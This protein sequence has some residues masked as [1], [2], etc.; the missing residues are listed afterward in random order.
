MTCRFRSAGL[1][2]VAVAASLPRVA[3]ADP[4]AARGYELAVPPLEIGDR[5]ARAVGESAA[6][7]PADERA[8]LVTC[9]RLKAKGGAAEADGPLLVDA[10]LFAS[11]VEAA[12][13][14]RAYRDRFDALLAQ[15]RGA[16]KSAKDDRE[17]G[18]VLMKCLH[19]T[20][21][22][23][24]YEAEQSS[25]AGAF[26]TGR[27][28]CVS[29]A[30]V[31]YA[32]GTRLGLKLRGISIPGRPFA[33]GHASLDLVVGDDRVQ[34][35]P[36]TPD[37]F[38]WAA[39]VKRPG[40]VVTGPLPD[41]TAGRE[42][43]ALGIVGMI[44]CNRGVA[45]ASGKGPERAKAARAYAAALALDPADPTAN[46]NAQTLFVNW[47]ADL[48]REKKFDDA[49][50]VLAFGLEVAPGSSS[51]RNNHRVAWVEAIDADLDRGDDNRAIERLGRA[52]RA[53][54]DDKDFRSAGDWYLRLAE[55]RI[56]DRADWE[57]G[58]AVLARAAKTLPA[59]EAKALSGFRGGVYRRWSQALLDKG[60]IDGSRTVLARLYALDPA[61]AG[62]AAGV[63]F[64]VQTALPI[65]EK[66]SAAAMAAHFKGLVEQFP[67][68]KEV[69]DGGAAHATRAVHR[70]AGEKKY[71]EAVT[72]IDGY[73]PLLPTAGERAELGGAVFDR[74]ARH[75][76]DAGEWR[77]A[78]DKYAEGLKAYPGH[79]LL[80][81]N[82]VALVDRWA[83]P[84]IKAKRWD[85]AI[86]VYQ[87]GLGLF[88]GNDHLLHNKKF[89][90][91]MKE[92]SR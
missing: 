80:S 37:G 83:D 32:V 27:Y 31:Y 54:P 92:S 88:P 73:R 61:D 18:E 84:A 38:D 39:K 30:A 79:K 68:L 65:A 5:L 72:A 10:M 13:A 75:L 15:A 8:L 2:A 89:C 86:G 24:G 49:V 51:M 3:A 23:K 22:K 16:V 12:D 57:A 34:V 53:M 45:L 91:A 25:F 6:A 11:G 56:G 43:D 48:L 52:A 33:P 50:R 17:R 82:G 35:E 29:S 60:D 7:F 55:R 58:L 41:R 28:N 19:D 63:A 1:L 20:V 44:Y 90:E 26:D 66:T 70:L 4:P 62:V 36:T 76:A 81:N 9:Q 69:P 77:Q 21:L 67:K 40:V 87:T 47:G 78:F 64:H 71:R 85:D 74:W 14:R 42:V 59:N 46:G